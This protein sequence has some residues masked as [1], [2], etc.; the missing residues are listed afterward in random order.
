MNQ[1]SDWRTSW[2]ATGAVRIGRLADCRIGLSTLVIQS[3]RDPLPAHWYPPC[4]DS[5]RSW[6]GEQNFTYRFVGD[7]LFDPLPD[8]ILQRTVDRTVVA[9]DL[10]RLYALREGLREGF[11]AVVWCDADV[12]IIRPDRLKLPDDAYALGRE[13]WVQGPPDDLRAYVKVHNA[14]LLFRQGNSFLEFYLDTALKLIRAHQGPMVPQLIGPKLLTAIH[15]VIGCPVFESFAVLS[16]LVVRDLLSGGASALKL[17][18]R[19]NS[20]TPAAVNLCGSMVANGEL[21]DEEIGALIDLLSSR[22]SV[23]G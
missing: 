18:Q 9:T 5:V 20:V 6:A 12:L 7:E 11:A 21:T 2:R 19:R 4:L 10:A 13:V 8:D 3:H 16:P 14:F 1:E 15:N 17:F 23:L 22:P